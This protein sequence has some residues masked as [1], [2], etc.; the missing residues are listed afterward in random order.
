[1]FKVRNSHFSMGRERISVWLGSEQNEGRASNYY[2]HYF[3]GK[4]MDGGFLCTFTKFGHGYRK[5]G[6]QR[7]HRTCPGGF[8]APRKPENTTPIVE[9]DNEFP[10]GAI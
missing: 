1:M 7:V 8:T 9:R 6:N 3:L 2:Q 4:A 5:R 10:C